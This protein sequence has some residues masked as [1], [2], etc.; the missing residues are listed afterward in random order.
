MVKAKT[1]EDTRYVWKKIITAHKPTTRKDELS[2]SLGSW[3]MLS[4]RLSRRALK[5]SIEGNILTSVTRRF[6]KTTKNL[7]MV[8]RRIRGSAQV[9]GSPL[10]CVIYGRSSSHRVWPLENLLWFCTSPWVRLEVASTAAKTTLGGVHKLRNNS[11][12]WLLNL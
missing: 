9:L 11:S 12:G 7:L 10:V 8:P 2:S 5:H 6:H 1:R 4:H 3:K